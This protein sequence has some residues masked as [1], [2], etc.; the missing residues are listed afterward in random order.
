[1][2]VVKNRI[3]LP[4]ILMAVF[5]L[6]RCPGVMPQNCSAAYA[7]VFCAGLYVPGRA[8]WFAPLITMAASDIVITQFFYRTPD[9]SWWQFALGQLPNYVAY[10]ALIGLGRAFGGKR[11][12]WLLVGGGV[13]GAVIFYI[14]TNT[15]AWMQLPYSKTLAGWFQALTTGLPGFPPTWEF[16][17]NTLLS[18]GIFTGL[19]VAAM[20]LTSPAESEEEKEAEAPATEPDGPEPKMQPAE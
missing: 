2:P 10:V 19:F 18:G 6:S 7:I 14:I 15:A 13:L 1:M 20:K 5:A 17:R 12:W 3:V 4:L 11:P 9:F 8:G 16:F